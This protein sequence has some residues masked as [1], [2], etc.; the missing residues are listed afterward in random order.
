MRLLLSAP[1]FPPPPPP[2]SAP[3]P[4]QVEELGSLLNTGEVPNLFDTAEVISAGEAVRSRARQAKMDGSRG[5]L[6]NFVV[7][8]VRC[9]GGR[10]G[11]G[12]MYWNVPYALLAHLGGRGP[13]AHAHV[14]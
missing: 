3:R 6:W 4:H 14:G 2:L 12:P 1:H 8:E 10:R 7:Q 11:G 13:H 5:D 9:A